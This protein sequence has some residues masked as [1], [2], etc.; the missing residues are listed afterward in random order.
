MSTRRSILKLFGA[1]PVAAPLVAKAA[2]EQAGLIGLKEMGGLLVG[3]AD[4]PQTPPTGWTSPAG[5]TGDMVP[6]A[7][8]IARFLRLRYLPS[9]Y[10]DEIRK[11]CHFVSFLDP[12]LASKRSWS[13]NVKIAAQRERNIQRSRDSIFENVTRSKLQQEFEQ[14]YG[15]WL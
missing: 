8:K 9:W 1:A 14:E 13:L 12:D 3:Q 10:D 15:V 7:T 4:Q 2:A 11:R 5:A 6:L